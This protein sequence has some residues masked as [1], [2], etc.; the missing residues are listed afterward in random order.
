MLLV[1][2]NGNRFELTI[3][4]YQFPETVDDEWDSN[5]L[6]I[7]IDVKSDWGTWHATDPS[8]LTDDVEGLAGW[9]EAV[10]E[11]RAQEREIESTGSLWRSL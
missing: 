3:T 10:A 2:K 7:R 4:G 6:N 5:W 11:G 9:L 1:G 8:L